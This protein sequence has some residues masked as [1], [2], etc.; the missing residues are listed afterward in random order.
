MI[1]LF[2]IDNRHREIFYINKIINNI[3]RK[4]KCYKS[5]IHSL[6][7]AFQNLNPQVLILPKIHKIERLE[8]MHSIAHIIY[9]PAEMYSGSDEG[10]L[11]TICHE[12]KFLKFID[13]RVCWGSFDYDILKNF[14]LNKTSLSIIGH[15]IIEQWEKSD[16][17]TGNFKVGIISTTR[18]LNNKNS[19]NIFESIYNVEYNA[20]D[21]GKSLYYR[22]N[23][24]AESWLVYELAFYRILLNI[25]ISNPNIEF[26]IRPHPSEKVEF[27][28]FISKKFRNVNLSTDLTYGEFL[29]SVNIVIG[30]ISAGL[31]EA[32]LRGLKVYSIRKLFPEWVIALLP[33]RLNQ[34]FEE[35][36]P[37]LSEVTLRLNGES[38]NNRKLQEF[39]KSYYNYPLL[40]SPSCKIAEL[41]NNLGA[42]KVKQK[43]FI[44]KG[45]RRFLSIKFGHKLLDYIYIFKRKISKYDTSSYYR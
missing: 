19:S 13:Y 8:E 24:H 42:S 26:I 11:Q 20:D 5:S 34:F 25:I 32:H 45:V 44:A 38:V 27:Y 37:S 14:Y 33:Y 22:E 43:K 2:A 4:H 21:A 39:C 41:I 23:E 1:I 28:K 3:D 6:D 35:M 15:P 36:L 9:I 16:I 12:L 10:F 18:V 7:L 29:S 40:F 30:H 17:N 31:I